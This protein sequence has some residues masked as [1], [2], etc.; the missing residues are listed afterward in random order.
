MAWKSVALAIMIALFAPIS[1]ASAQVL[2]CFPF[3]PFFCSVDTA[4]SLDVVGCKVRGLKKRRDIVR[5][6]YKHFLKREADSE[7]LAHWASKL[8]DGG[9][10]KN[11][12]GGLVESEEYYWKNGYFLELHEH[13]NKLYIDV[14]GR[15]PESNAALTHWVNNTG[16]KGWRSTASGIGRSVEAGKRWESYVER[17]CKMTPI[18]GPTF[19]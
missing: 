6:L 2:D 1:S 18:K 19:C 9:C 12:V 17:G 3:P 11:V 4:G 5:Q 15:L 14:L 16:S 10:V 13:V 7:G 8:K